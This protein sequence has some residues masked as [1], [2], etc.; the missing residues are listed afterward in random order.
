MSVTSADVTRFVAIVIYKTII[1]KFGCDLLASRVY[2][3]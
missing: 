3:Q 1:V 2:V